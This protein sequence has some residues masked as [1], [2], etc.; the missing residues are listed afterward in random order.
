MKLMILVLSALLLAN[1]TVNAYAQVTAGSP[2]ERG[3]Q[4]IKF[5][6]AYFGT[7]GNKIEVTPGDKN[8][9]F[10]VVFANVG[11][12]DITGVRGQLSLPL[13]FSSADGKSGIIYADSG[14]EVLGGRYSALTF[15]VNL[16]K[17]VKIQQYPG[18]V[19]IDY[20]RFREAGQ[21]Q[22]FFDFTFKVTGESIVNLRALDP[23]LTSIQNNKVVVEVSNTGSA[24]ISDV[25]IILQNTDTAISSTATSITNVEN[26]VF[27]QSD[28]SLGT[29]EPG[30]LR[31]FEFQVYIPEG[32][33][34][35]TLHTIMD[36]TYF[37]AQGVQINAKRTVDFFIKG[38]IDARIYNIDVINLAG[39]QTVIGEIINEGNTNALFAFVTLEPLEGSNIKK[40]TQ[41]IDEL[42]TDSPVPFNIPV[43]FD[44]EPKYGDHKI[45]VTVRY[46]DDLRNEHLISQE[47]TVKL[48]DLSKKLEPKITD[49]IPAIIGVAVAVVIGIFVLKKLKKKENP[50]P[51]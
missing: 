21:R 33:R 50:I 39:K 46:K 43:A 40:T 13:G 49:Y 42:E 31:N 8:V 11:T 44:G 4:D 41:F 48:E 12:I 15:Y 36:I 35:D 19:K 32:V 1:I 18:T 6:N 22:A 47:E 2:F 37:N 28:W 20:S 24:P 16:D 26:V 3:Y 9:P 5:T 27:D 17:T 14:A 34:S 25:R 7:F 23:F 38:F 51:S 30:S 45:K 10:T 29:I